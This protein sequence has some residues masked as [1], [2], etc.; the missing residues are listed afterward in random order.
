MFSKSFDNL[1]LNFWEYEIQGLIPKKFLRCTIALGRE[2][3]E[4]SFIHIIFSQ[5]K[6]DYSW[7]ISPCWSTKVNSRILRFLAE[8][9]FFQWN[10]LPF[11]RSISHIEGGKQKMTTFYQEDLSY[12]DSLPIQLGIWNKEKE[13]SLFKVKIC[14][15]YRVASGFLSKR[16]NKIKKEATVTISW[17]LCIMTG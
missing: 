4:F 2:I 15:S 7:E 12:K 16:P 8:G 17:F 5:N 11:A 3:H 1:F 6:E 13:I 10:F 14:S 9:N